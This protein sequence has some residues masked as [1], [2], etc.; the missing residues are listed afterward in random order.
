MTELP[1]PT[2]RIVG[3]MVCVAVMMLAVGLL[4]PRS[5][6]PM[7]ASEPT[8]FAD[9]RAHPASSELTL[10][11]SLGSRFGSSIAISGSRVVVG[12]PDAY[13]V[14]QAY[15][16]HPMTGVLIATLTTPDP[17]LIGGF[18]WSV[19]ISGSTVV[20][21]SPFET[22]SG[23]EEAG[24][25]YFFNSNTGAPI[26]TL[27]SPNV[28]ISG[29]FGDS[30]AACGAYVVIG[31]PGE[32]GSQAEG[33][34]H[35]YVFNMTTG[36]LVHTLTS[37]NAQTDGAF[38]LSVALDGARVV[39]GAP[40]EKAAGYPQSG[41]AYL[42]KISDGALVHILTSPNARADAGYDLFGS[43]VA[44]G[45]STVVVSAPDELVDGDVYVF[46]ATTHALTSTLY[47]PQPVEGGYFGWSVAIHGTS[48]LVGAPY[49]TAND[50]GSAGNAYIFE[51]T[52][53][54]LNS[55]LISPNAQYDGE[56][57]FS[58][59][60]DSTRIAAG[61]PDEAIDGYDGGGDAYVFPLT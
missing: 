9:L 55:T 53:G 36:A 46:N 35:A 8:S 14:G 19:A 56:F 45:G 1:A 32:A 34:G 11:G 59:A 23:D 47:S 43:S 16:F 61:A 37:P 20:V 28:Q 48:V 30:V 15:I 52:T 27:S 57:G 60:V 6:G 21:G 7:A 2:K 26:R 33:A 42:F 17:T 31:A 50:S 51:A 22:V 29:L 3:V 13:S 10:R 38:G 40:D 41:H 39:V 58:L 54:A 24:H 18:G 49:E 5:P 25:V 4:A 12:A 44:I